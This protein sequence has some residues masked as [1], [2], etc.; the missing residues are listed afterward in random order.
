MC[1]RAAASFYKTFGRGSKRDSFGYFFCFC[2]NWILLKR[3][4]GIAE[5]FIF[6][7][8]RFLHAFSCFTDF[9]R[10]KIRKTNLRLE[11]MLCCASF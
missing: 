6:R 7:K 4:F 8:I 9:I 1:Q 5:A 11:G 2:R 3:N 10:G